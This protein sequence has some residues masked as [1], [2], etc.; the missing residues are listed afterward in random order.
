M[1]VGLPEEISPKEKVEKYLD[2]DSEDVVE[3]WEADGEDRVEEGKTDGSK[4]EES[5]DASVESDWER[6]D[7]VVQGIYAK[8]VIDRLTADPAFEALIC[9]IRDLAEQFASDKLAIIQR[10]VSSAI[11]GVFNSSDSQSRQAR[12]KVHWNLEAYLRENYDD[13]VA[14]DLNNILATTGVLPNA[15]LCTVAEYLKQVKTWKSHNTE[16]LQALREALDKRNSNGSTLPVVRTPI[17]TE[18]A[19]KVR[20]VSVDLESNTVFAEGSEE[21]II[22]IAQQLGWL[23]AVTCD[24][25]GLGETKYAYASV[26]ELSHDTTEPRHPETLFDVSVNL[27]IPPV[28]DNGSCWIKILGPSVLITGYPT[29]ERRHSERGLEASPQ[30]MANFAGMPIAV[31]FGGGFVFKGRYH[32]MVPIKRF[33]GSVQ[34]HVISSHSNE[35]LEWHDILD[36]C[37]ERLP[38]DGSKEALWNARSFFGWCS[39]VVSDFATSQFDFGGLSWSTARTP[40]RLGPFEVSKLSLGLSKVVTASVDAVPRK[41]KG[42][43]RD[44]R[45]DDYEWILRRAHTL[46]VI[47]HGSSD[48]RAVQLDGEEAILHILLH[49]RL[50]LEKDGA[51]TAAWESLE[52]ACPTRVKTV[53]AAMNFNAD[54]VYRTTIKTNERG[55]S[56]ILFKQ[57]VVN[58]YHLIS[59]LKARLYDEP[60][61]EERGRDSPMRLQIPLRPRQLFGWEYMELVNDTTTLFEEC[62]VTL[63]KSCGKWYRYARDIKA[64]PLFVE[65]LGN[66][67]RPEHPEQLCPGLRELPTGNSYLAVTLTALWGLFDR[68]SSL[69]D[70]TRLT[71]SGYTIFGRADIFDQ[72][73]SQAASCA[74]SRTQMVVREDE[75]L[76]LREYISAL[77]QPRWNVGPKTIAPRS[78]GCILFGLDPELAKKCA[79]FGPS[80]RR[81]WTR[82]PPLAVHEDSGDD[83]EA[84][85]NT[86]I[87]VLNGAVT[88]EIED[89]SDHV[90]DP[91]LMAPSTVHAT[92]NIAAESSYKATVKAPGGHDPIGPREFVMSGAL[93]SEM[94]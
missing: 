21:F 11:G 9:A 13:G 27:E 31:T 88:S 87:N 34:W 75:A 4:A 94:E 55:T 47:F 12:F 35:E 51:N 92:P 86:V 61:E 42:V 81:L 53:R 71:K 20:N 17:V 25:Y 29:A 59:S 44:M 57:E 70:Q 63:D 16:L 80:F 6:D 30:M 40:Q 43:A 15:Q 89:R 10:R 8:E 18:Q 72:C 64:V 69:T 38:H 90:V 85:T 46:P 14:H 60:T 26:K 23:A 66:V 19:S 54:R 28:E 62:G 37:P 48:R 73:C 50:C 24:S 91:P 84:P 22:I 76:K 41:G 49:R 2:P 68:Q 77:N 65:N 67:V 93:L 78:S 39:S 74:C 83:E 5:P 1:F 58:V 36:H 56:E 82:R 33:E 45:S 79:G 7:L 52:A 3:E 32:A